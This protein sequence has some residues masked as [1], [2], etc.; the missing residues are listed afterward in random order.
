MDKI[1]EI[2]ASI[3][4]ECENAKVTLNTSSLDVLIGWAISAHLSTGESPGTTIDSL[5]KVVNAHAGND[6]DIVTTNAQCVSFLESQLNDQ[7]EKN[8]DLQDALREIYSI[9]G[10]DIRIAEIIRKA[11]KD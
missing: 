2:K 6:L 1:T 9:A 4:Y 3:S 10:E 7:L 8:E 5:I 11:V